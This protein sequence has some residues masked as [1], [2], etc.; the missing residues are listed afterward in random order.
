MFS[1]ILKQKLKTKKSHN[2]STHANEANKKFRILDFIGYA[3]PWRLRIGAKCHCF[4]HMVVKGV[5]TCL[6][7]R[8]GPKIPGNIFKKYLKYWYEFE[9]LVPFKLV[10]LWLE[11]MILAP[12]PQLEISSKIIK[13]NVKDR[14]RFSTNFCNVSKR[15]PFQTLIHPWEP[16]NVAR[17][18]VRR[19]GELGHNH[20]FVF[21]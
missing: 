9:T 21:N 8:G 19:V 3:P 14:Q 11:A 7:V 18:E 1:L 13:V 16:K 5:R 10:P 12:L 17:R 6:H 15:P 20:L 2:I 4:K